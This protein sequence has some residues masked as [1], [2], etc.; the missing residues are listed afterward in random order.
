MM[1]FLVITAMTVLSVMAL[2]NVAPLNVTLPNV[3]QPNFSR[4]NAKAS[5]FGFAKSAAFPDTVQ[6]VAG[7]HESKQVKTAM[8][9]TNKLDQL[10]DFLRDLPEENSEAM[11]I[12]ELDGFLAGVLVCPEMIPPSTW[13]PHV[14]SHKGDGSHKPVYQSIER[15]QK[16]LDLI[17]H[18]YNSIARNL[19][20]GTKEGYEPVTSFIEATG[21]EFCMVWAAGF[22]RA[23]N[24]VPSSW[25]SII[26]SGDSDAVAA[27]KSLRTLVAISNGE[28]TLP[29]EEQ[30]RFLEAAPDA[31]SE[32]I[33]IL[34]DWRL[35]HHAL[36]P[37]TAQTAFRDTGR[38]APC[39]CGSGRKYKK[40]HGA[41]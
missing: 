33:E 12:E 13:M 16:I 24:L 21:E 6:A 3:A 2:F 8:A 25:L 18:H 32:W 27:L 15:A 41:N 4:L 1:I 19:L 31:I 9:T 14:W 7:K 38:N 29:D 17:M 26:K 11:L 35:Q 22:E 23:L 36:A 37:V 34:S 5:L 30:S 20:P 40:C 39:P 28:S 10:S